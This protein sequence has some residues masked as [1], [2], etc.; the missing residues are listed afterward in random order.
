ML[1]NITE[2]M[3]SLCRENHFL[4]SEL[5][6]P[7][8]FEKQKISFPVEEGDDDMFALFLMTKKQCALCFIGTRSLN[9]KRMSK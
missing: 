9:M 6:K 1:N 8:I 7:D 3:L 5:A 2:M 4:R